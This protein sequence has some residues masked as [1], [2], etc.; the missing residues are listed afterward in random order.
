G[1]GLSFYDSGQRHLYRWPTSTAAA[2]TG[3]SEVLRPWGCAQ[4][5]AYND[6]IANPKTTSQSTP[7]T[8]GPPMK[9]IGIIPCSAIPAI[10]PARRQRGN[11]NP[12]TRNAS[13][14]MDSTASGIKA[15][16]SNQVSGSTSGP[17]SRRR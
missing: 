10:S 7:D 12:T 9:M 14:A 11:Q 3:G 2:R 15:R 6:P 17:Y 13:T 8:P 16:Q 5:A 1:A 4:N